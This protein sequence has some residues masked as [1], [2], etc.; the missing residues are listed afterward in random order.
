MKDLCDKFD[1]TQS[2]SSKCWPYENKCIESFHSSIEK[3]E[4]FRNIY[5]NYEDTKKSIFEYIEGWYNSKRLNSDLSYAN[6]NEFEL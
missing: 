5:S 6:T 3:E 4:I 2:F 1:I